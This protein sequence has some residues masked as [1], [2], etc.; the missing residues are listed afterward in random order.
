MTRLRLTLIFSLLLVLQ[1]NAQLDSLK[2]ILTSQEGKEKS[3]TWVNL[4][5]AYVIEG[6]DSIA[7][8]E[9]LRALGYISDQRDTATM[10]QAM[11]YLYFAAPEKQERFEWLK[12]SEKS[13]IY[14]HKPFQ[15]HIR[16]ALIIE[17]QDRANFEEA[18]KLAIRN[19][20]FSKELNDTL[21]I[22]NSTLEHGYTLDRMKNYTEAISI[23]EGLFPLTEAYG[24][25][26]LL[27]RN[28]GLIGI[29]YDELREYGLAIEYNLKSIAYFRSADQETSDARMFLSI[30]LSN[31]GNT[32]TK[33]KE[34]KLA[35]EALKESLKIKNTLGS[36]SGDA[37]ININLGKLKMDMGD[38]TEAKEYLDIGMR[39]A[40]VYDLVRFQSEA[41]KRMGEFHTR[42]SEVDSALY[43]LE[44]YHFLNDS[45]M[46][47]EKMSQLADLQV[48]YK[49]AEKER[50]N[51]LLLQR[52]EILALERDRQRFWFFGSLGLLALVILTSFLFYRIH[53]A[54]ESA[55]SQARIIT[56]RERGITAMIQSVEEE[57]QRIAKDLHDGIGQQMTAIKLK[58][59]S[60]QEHLKISDSEKATSITDLIEGTAKDIRSVSHQMMPRALTE[61]GLVPALRDMIEQSLDAAGI[62]YHFEVLG[63]EI[64]LD[65]AI[66]IG[67]FRVTQELINNIIKHSG[68]KHVEIQLFFRQKALI[69]TIEDDGIGIKDSSKEGVGMLNIF[70][71]VSALKGEARYEEA[72]GTGTVAVIRVPISQKK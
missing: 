59:N 32:Y 43:H 28:W 25:P 23:Y 56:E 69:L 55:R 7:Y 53:R 36:S 4:T 44:R 6:Q 18:L 21:C 39:L 34:Y 42:K 20:A 40:H 66:E 49:T 54:K 50:E 1:V 68:A 47:A 19:V 52:N 27:G 61:L 45:L 38:M 51:E 16:N 14:L 2:S 65:Q 8:Q 11:Y 60:I 31:L 13:S 41:H 71:R 26:I 64:R 12:R 70:N 62:P 37:I 3:L 67:I 58:W 22:I 48:F 17:Y 30:W 33:T 35:E 29:A 57:R 24:D 5:R 46:N 15:Y 72:G 10:A 63:A 9:G